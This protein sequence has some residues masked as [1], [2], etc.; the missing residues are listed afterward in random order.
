M[1]QKSN[2]TNPETKTN[3]LTQKETEAI[4]ASIMAS[5]SKPPATP[6]H[7]DTA[8]AVIPEDKTCYVSDDGQ[9]R[10][11]QLVQQTAKFPPSPYP[12]IVLQLFPKDHTRIRRLESGGLEAMLTG[13]EIE[14]FIDA[15]NNAASASGK[16]KVFAVLQ[17][18]PEKTKQHK[19]KWREY[20]ETR[21]GIRKPSGRWWWGK[22]KHQGNYSKH[23]KN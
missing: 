10:I 23:G 18:V 15:Y 6:Y 9:L 7:Q 14:Q 5:S 2:N 4:V 11:E 12:C 22:R 1:D 13:F 20:N 21:L 17:R 3:P 19:R 16:G 8:D